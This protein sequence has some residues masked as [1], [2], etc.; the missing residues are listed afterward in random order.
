VVLLLGT[1]FGNRFPG[2]VQAVGNAQQPPETA[3]LKAFDPDAMSAQQRA[4][5]VLPC[6]RTTGPV[7]LA[8]RHQEKERGDNRRGAPRQHERGHIEPGPRQRQ[9]P[10]GQRAEPDAGE[11][12]GGQQWRSGGRGGGGLLAALQ[13]RGFNVLDHGGGQSGEIRQGLCEIGEGFILP[14]GGPFRLGLVPAGLPLGLA[15]GL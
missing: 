4:G 13:K 1:G 2:V 14:G 6:G 3:A 7:Q 9:Q 15:K 12:P 10:G 5:R 8:C 11:P